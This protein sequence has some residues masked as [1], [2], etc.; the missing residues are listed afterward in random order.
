MED[1]KLT[2]AAGYRQILEDGRDVCNSE[3]DAE[4]SDHGEV[5]EGMYTEGAD[6][7]TGKPAPCVVEGTVG[8]GTRTAVSSDD[9]DLNFEQARA[10]RRFKKGD[11]V[12][13][14]EKA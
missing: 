6:D 2:A 13:D 4:Y 14:L 12:T 1:A 10:L 9:D 8:S 7:G 3:T 11:L 5:L